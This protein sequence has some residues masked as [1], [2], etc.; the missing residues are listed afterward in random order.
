[1]RNSLTSQA[2]QE[3]LSRNADHNLAIHV[4]PMTYKMELG[5]ALLSLEVDVEEKLSLISMVGPTGV[6]K[7]WLIRLLVQIAGST[8]TDRLPITGACDTVGRVSVYHASTWRS[9]NDHGRGMH[10]KTAEGGEM[11]HAAPP[12]SRLVQLFSTFMLHA[13]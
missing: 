2:T 11:R 4:S 8:D 5:D 3:D 9:E 13:D 12:Y 1:M 6:G 10:E 7:S